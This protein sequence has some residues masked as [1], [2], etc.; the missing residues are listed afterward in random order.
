MMAVGRNSHNRMEVTKCTRNAGAV[1]TRHVW[2][3]HRCPGV[4]SVTP[5]QLRA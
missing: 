3:T 1:T 4:T 5:Q 2:H